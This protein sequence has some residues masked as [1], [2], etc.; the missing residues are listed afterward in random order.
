MLMFIRVQLGIVSVNA[1][2]Q[3]L[4]MYFFAIKS[5]AHR[6]RTETKNKKKINKREENSSCARTHHFLRFMFDSEMR[7]ATALSCSVVVGCH[8]YF[9]GKW[10]ITSKAWRAH[11]DE[12]IQCVRCG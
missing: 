5:I 7:P 1:T 2:K 3:Y 9:N 4:A 10:K 12:C 11:D 8:H 6:L